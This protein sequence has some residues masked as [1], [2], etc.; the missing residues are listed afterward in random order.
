MIDPQAESIRMAMDQAWRDHH[1]VR[2]QTWHAVQIE[3]VLAAGVVTIDLQY[4]QPL[5]TAIA[6][7]PLLIAGVFGILVSLHHRQVEVVKFE[8]IYNCEKALGLIRED[9]ISPKRIRP[10][11]PLR[12]WHVFD[13]RV[14][15]QKVGP[16]PS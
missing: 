3:A 1:H 11:S 6:F 15:F 12:W 10:A 9:L 14:S 7:V 4:Q 5:A 8:Q 16:P 2:D 13:F